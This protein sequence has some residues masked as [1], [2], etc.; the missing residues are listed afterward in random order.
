MQN[1]IGKLAAQ[2]S[3]LNTRREVISNNV[4]NSNTP[5]F[6][7]QDVIFRDQL[8]NSA[9]LQKPSNRHT[10]SDSRLYQTNERHITLSS[11]DH[12]QFTTNPNRVNDDG[13]NVDVTEQMIELMKITQ[14][15]SFAVQAVNKQSE[16]NR[17]ARGQ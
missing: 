15:Q 1:Y 3:F 12:V 9:R 10:G 6:K 17:A 2:M 4:A 7:A 8:E 11:N 16:I 14:L 13:N 5:N